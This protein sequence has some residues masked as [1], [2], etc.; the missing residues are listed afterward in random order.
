MM[1]GCT[2]ALVTWATWMC[3]LVVA[4]LDNAENANCPTLGMD[5][6]AMM[7]V[8]KLVKIRNDSLPAQPVGPNFG[9][10]IYKQRKQSKLNYGKLMKIVKGFGN[11]S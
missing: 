2:L 9:G 10:D 6:N 8:Q 5:E 3:P 7:Q 1:M 4:S 11:D